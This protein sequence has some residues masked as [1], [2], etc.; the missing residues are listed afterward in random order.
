MNILKIPLKYL[1]NFYKL[2]VYRKSK[3]LLRK[4][5]EIYHY[6]FSMPE[7]VY[8]AFLHT[9][10]LDSPEDR[11]SSYERL[12]FLGD[13][14][15]E[16][17]VSNYLFD[18]YNELTEGDLTKMRSKLVNKI[19]LSKISKELGFNRLLKISKG[20][21]KEN[22]RNLDSILSDIY[23]SFIGAL[24]LDGKLKEAEKFIETTLLSKH[25]SLLPSPDIQNNK[26]SLLEYCQHNNISA[27]KFI[28]TNKNG[29]AHNLHFE[30]SILINNK[31]YGSGLARTKKSAEQIASRKTLNLL[32]NKK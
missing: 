25:K 23:E 11:N 29:L 18:T 2:V 10:G 21:E 17:V 32:K 7:L 16:L 20:A 19:T 27:P 12:E 31:F 5:Y 3:R 24:Y 15:L 1:N 22:I 6:R 14:V 30:I 4:V 8:Q 26:G 28:V 9:S 13:A